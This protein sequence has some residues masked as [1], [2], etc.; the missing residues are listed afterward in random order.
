MQAQKIAACLKHFVAHE[1]EKERK[2]LDSIVD[3]GTPRELYIYPFQLVMTGHQA[4]DYGNV[5][6]HISHTDGAYVLVLVLASLFSNI[7][8]LSNKYNKTHSNFISEYSHLI[9][10]LLREE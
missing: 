3:E 1:C 7:Y 9:Q 8:M 2:I 4:I 6:S 10:S 5:V